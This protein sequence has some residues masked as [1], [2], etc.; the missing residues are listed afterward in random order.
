MDNRIMAR[1]RFAGEA[2]ESL[3]TEVSVG[4]K[5]A[6]NNPL[7]GLIKDRVSIRNSISQG[8]DFE[9]VQTEKLLS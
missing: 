5:K 6:L 1:P 4:S 2:L 9:G 7:M 8:A 3:P